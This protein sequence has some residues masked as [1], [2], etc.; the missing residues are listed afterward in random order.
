V[1]PTRRGATLL[2]ATAGALALGACGSDNNT[3]S[4]PAGAA[5]S[6][7][8]GAA[9]SAG[10]GAATSA[11]GGGIS[12]AGGTLNLAGST[13]QGPAISAWKKTYQSTCSGA[14]V[15]D[16]AGGSGAG[17]TGFI[18]GT[19][20]FAGSDY[21]L[22]AAQKPDADKRCGTGGAVDVP[23][24]PG[25]VAIVYNL[26]GVSTL[27]LSA[28]N[29]ADIFAGKIKTWNDPAL[30]KDNSGLPSTPIQTF[31]RSDGSGTSFNFSNY[32]TNV[33]KANWSYGANKQWPAPE[34]IGQGA[35]GSAGIAQGVKSTT[36]AISYVDYS[37]AKP[38][39]IP[40]AQVGR[41]DGSFA[42][43]TSDAVS[44]FIAP[45]K[46]GGAG[47]NDTTLSFDYT[48]TAGYPVPLVTYEF[49]CQSGNKN[50]ALLKGFL[51][52]AASDAG[53]QLLPDLGY[54]K[55]PTTIQQKVQQEIMSLS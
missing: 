10:G 18:N 3:T 46:A 44:A 6:A 30:A 13:A 45:A 22:T 37:Y 29:L 48:Q 42:E 1:K 25:G 54:V 26:P 31:H 33:A 38:N 35:K 8:G 16:A 5:T 27:K 53:Q 7:G 41:A 9:T 39:S 34:N 40:F 36:G 4:S 23:L 43:L 19:I 12:C 20:D 2:M 52:Y 51:G 49:V 47:G 21:P 17:A 15:N 24:V 50:G 11:G 28:Q 55:L 14:S 32:L